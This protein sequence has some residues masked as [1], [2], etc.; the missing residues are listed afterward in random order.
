MNAQNDIKYYANDL[1]QYT[2]YLDIQLLDNM[3]WRFIND[4]VASQLAQS[5]V[6]QANSCYVY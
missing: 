6:E 2:T 1:I 5:Y 4:W 3:L